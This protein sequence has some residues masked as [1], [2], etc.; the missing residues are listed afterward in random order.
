VTLAQASAAWR[1]EAMSSSGGPCILVCRPAQKLPVHMCCSQWVQTC[2][3]YQ[4]SWLHEL[5][6]PDFFKVDSAH[7]YS[8]FQQHLAI[9][10]TRYKHWCRP[11][12]QVGPK[13]EM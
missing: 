9:R 3:L 6:A 4:P 10:S 5:Q 1:C 11:E 13:S 2:L 8:A 12:V 7:V